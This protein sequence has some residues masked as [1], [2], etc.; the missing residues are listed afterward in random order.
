MTGGIDANYTELKTAEVL[1]KTGWTSLPDLPLTR[2]SH[3]M[4][5]RDEET[6]MAIGGVEDNL[7]C[8]K[9]VHILNRGNQVLAKNF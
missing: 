4:T 3:C 7:C 9:S 2:S 5:Y 6:L 8:S 1:T